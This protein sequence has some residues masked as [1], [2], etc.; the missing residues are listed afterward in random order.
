[1]VYVILLGLLV[2]LYFMLW[3]AST[4]GATPR[5]SGS[6]E[7]GEEALSASE[8]SA[9]SGRGF[10]RHRGLPIRYVYLRARKANFRAQ[11]HRFDEPAKLSLS[12]VA[13]L[14]SPLPFHLAMSL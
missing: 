5:C 11:P 9:P 14:Q 6:A 4:G 10:S 1:M 13:S 12:M 2:A 3:P 7:N 8:H